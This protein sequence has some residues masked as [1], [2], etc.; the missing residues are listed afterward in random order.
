M[1][2]G[3]AHM[4]RCLEVHP[5]IYSPVHTT[6]M[7]ENIW[8]S[9]LN[10]NSSCANPKLNTEIRRKSIL[11]HSCVQFVNL[12]VYLGIQQSFAGCEASHQTCRTVRYRNTNAAG[13]ASCP[14]L[15]ICLILHS[16]YLF[17]EPPMAMAWDSYEQKSNSSATGTN[18]N[19]DI[20]RQRRYRM[21]LCL[22]LHVDSATEKPIIFP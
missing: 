11:V 5:Q 3:N 9:V 16:L 10:L 17:G 22:Y 21:S 19:D 15:C 4:H 13:P 18:A 12:W 20:V 2:T 6:C 1:C 14:R 7:T 8:A